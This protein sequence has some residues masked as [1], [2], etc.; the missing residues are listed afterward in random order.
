MTTNPPQSRPVV[1]T[2]NRNRILLIVVLLFLVSVPSLIA[3]LALRPAVPFAKLARL[4]P[5]MS[6]A[7]VRAILGTPQ[8]R[9][10]DDCLIYRRFANPGWVEVYFDQHDKLDHFNDESGGIKDLSPPVSR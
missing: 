5:G 9:V 2:K 1:T 6:R 10:G 3:Y 7:E 4:K 8:D